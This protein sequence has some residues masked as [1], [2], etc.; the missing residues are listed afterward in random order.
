MPVQIASKILIYSISLLVEGDGNGTWGHK[1]SAVLH[2]MWSRKRE[3]AG[4]ERVTEDQ[5]NVKL[6]S[7]G[8]ARTS[9]EK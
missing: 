3:G 7:N 6:A 8:Q 5:T 9:I 2:K 4:Y 1:Q